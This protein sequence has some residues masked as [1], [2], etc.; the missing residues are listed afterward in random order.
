MYLALLCAPS[1]AASCPECLTRSPLPFGCQ[2][3]Q[4]EEEDTAFDIEWGAMGKLPSRP[5]V[6]FMLHTPHPLT[7]PLIL[8][9]SPLIPHRGRPTPDPSQNLAAV[10]P[11]EDAI[12]MRS[13]SRLLVDVDPKASKQADCSPA[14]AL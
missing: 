10:T 4:E 7:P 6:Q 2:H 14:L 1:F 9:I 3:K 12:L 13:V 11:D 5:P 8:H